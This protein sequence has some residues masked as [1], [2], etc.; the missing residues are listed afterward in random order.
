MPASPVSG[1]PAVVA[2]GS[3][4]ELKIQR[5]LRGLPERIVHGTGPPHTKSVREAAHARFAAVAVHQM[6]IL[7]T[8]AR[9]LRLR[10][11]AL[12]SFLSGS[13]DSSQD[14]GGVTGVSDAPLRCIEVFVVWGRDEE[15]R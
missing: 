9:S 10:I 7:K 4:V 1:N 3:F 2:G 5:R 15:P 13:T 14:P 12:G 11:V 8:S 6:N